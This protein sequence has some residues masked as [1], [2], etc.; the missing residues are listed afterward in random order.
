MMKFRGFSVLLVALAGAALL[1]GCKPDP[2]AS[3]MASLNCSS[4][5]TGSASSEYGLQ[6]LA[7]E[8]GYANSGH[9]NGTRVFNVA[10]AVTSTGFLFQFQGSHAR[11]ENSTSCSQC[12][13]DQGFV[14]WLSTGT[15]GVQA[16][17]SPPGCFT[18]HD[19][20]DTGDFSL[21]AQGAVA[22][23]DGSTYD[24]GGGNLCVDCHHAR[25]AATTL[26]VAANWNTKTNPHQGVQGDFILGRDAWLFQPASSYVGTSQHAT[27][28]GDSCVSCHTFNPATGY[29]GSGSLQWG[30]HAFYQ[31]AQTTI[32]GPATSTY[33]E[34]DQVNLCKTCHTTPAPGATFPTVDT[35][36][37]TDWVGGGAGTGKDKLVQ[38]RMLRDKL[39][40]YFTTV[41]GATKAAT[42]TSA[43]TY[44]SL[45][46]PAP[47]AA[48]AVTWEW[49]R[50]FILNSNV[51]LTQV[52]A[53]AYWDLQLFLYDRSN[54]IHNPTFAAQILYD[55][56]S[57]VG[58]VVGTRPT[59]TYP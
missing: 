29:T 24:H 59:Y 11:N 43:T 5:H 10:S 33:S 31:M 44:A 54:G 14:T 56:C 28:P 21:R 41:G 16:P 46:Y 53:E 23:V 26:T 55:S 42:I 39:V 17:A 50:D 25:T 7:N 52:Q 47:W 20:H 13:T 8:E 40:N 15:A 4:C 19:P 51:A 6:M 57:A 58:L 30:G 32:P 49:N 38:I 35:P 2:V 12:H 9:Y 36:P 45:T 48:T 34:A 22:L 37:A 27:A 18:C 3:G 1:S